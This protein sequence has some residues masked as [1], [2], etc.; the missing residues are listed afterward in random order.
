M[1]INTLSDYQIGYDAY[2]DGLG[3]SDA[4]STLPNPTNQ[5][6]D[7]YYEGWTACRLKIEAHVE[8]QKSK[9]IVK[10]FKAFQQ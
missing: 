6:L 7:D 3:L 4:W 9:G 1:I 5:A 8:K 10:P 2:I